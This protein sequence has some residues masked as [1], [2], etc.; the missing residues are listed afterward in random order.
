[1][2]CELLKKKFLRN[3]GSILVCIS[4]WHIVIISII[5]VMYA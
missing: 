1:M 4:P 2:N 3:A 5:K